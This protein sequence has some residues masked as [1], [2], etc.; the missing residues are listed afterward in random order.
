MKIK[1]VIFLFF[2]ICPSILA[3]SSKLSISG[4]VG[5]TLQDDITFS[6]SYY[7]YIDDCAQYGG[8]LEYMLRPALSLGVSFMHMDTHV[9]I[10]DAYRNKVSTS[11]NDAAKLNYLMFEVTKYLGMRGAF[12]VVKPFAGIGTG[13]A[14][15]SVTSG[16]YT[17]FAWSGK[18]GVKIQ[19]TPH[20]SALGQ[21]QLQSIMQGIGNTMYIGT[22][23]SGADISVYSS[24][25]Q[26]TFGGGL[27]F[28]L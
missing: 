25:Y 18:A 10:Y 26:F 7:G 6:D 22:G 23:G 20:I 15:I 1:S 21:I 28:N 12:S 3:Q 5:Y 8:I 9:P 2:F 16:T 27:S 19:L 11:D 4:F 14:M 17:K 13:L 24:T